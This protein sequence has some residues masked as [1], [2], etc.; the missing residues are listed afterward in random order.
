LLDSIWPI[1]QI[2]DDLVVEFEEGYE[3]Q[4]R[5]AMLRCLT[6]D[7]RQFSVPITADFK[8]G[9]TWADLAD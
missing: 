5:D 2:H 4:V 3:S 7:S 8:A 9:R 1:L 6:A